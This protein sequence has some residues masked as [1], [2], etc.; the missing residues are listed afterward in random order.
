[1]MK[2]N[3]PVGEARQWIRV[4]ETDGMGYLFENM[5]KMDIQAE[6]ENT[7]IARAEAEAAKAEAKAAAEAAVRRMIL[8]QRDMKR[9]KEE[10]QAE[11]QYIFELDED[12]ARDKIA[13][14]W[15]L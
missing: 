12:T 8:R 4:L 6:R 15:N 9:T 10:T 5:E 1:M 11:L 3:V 2:M 7:R 13:L 14:Y